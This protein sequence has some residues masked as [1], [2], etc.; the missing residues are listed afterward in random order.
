MDQIDAAK[1][2]FYPSFDIRAFIGL[3]ALHLSDLLRKSS[4]Q[5]NLVPGLSLPIFDSGRLN[6]NLAATRSQSNLLIAQ[7]NE[8]VLNAV[9]EV[10]QAGIELD[11]LSAQQAMQAGKLKAVTFAADS[12]TA[13]Y[14]RGLLDKATAREALLPVLTEQSQAVGIRSRQI[15][16]AVT[17][18]AVLGGGYVAEGARRSIAP[19]F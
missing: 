12:A 17:L 10:A 16:A 18:A 19:A 3:D 2:A 13:H 8:A 14:R 6:A 7:Y 1:A 9:R 5:I 11:D 4:P 15:H